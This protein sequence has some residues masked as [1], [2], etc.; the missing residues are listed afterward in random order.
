MIYDQKE[1]DIVEKISPTAKISNWKD[2]KWQLK[3]VVR[4]IHTFETLLFVFDKYG[5]L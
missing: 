3:H 1:Q 5:R 2:W 4:D